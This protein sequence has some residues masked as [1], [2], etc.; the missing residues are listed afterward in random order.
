[1][2]WLN[3]KTNWEVKPLVDGMYQGDWFNYSDYNRIV[4]N[5]QHLHTLGQNILGIVF[6]IST[7][8]PAVLNAFPKAV[9]FNTVEDSLYALTQNIYEPPTYP[10]KST[11]LGNSA[12]PTYADL[13]RIEGACDAIYAYLYSL[14][15]EQAFVPFGSDELLTSDGE[16]FLV[17]EEV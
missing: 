7:M 16:T 14:I 15:V 12:A 2:A 4:S 5:L 8:S 9:A 10:G 11:W 6:S 1:M 13:N 3:P 17:I